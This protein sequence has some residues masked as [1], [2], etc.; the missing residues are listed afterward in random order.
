MRHHQILV[1]VAGLALGATTAVTHASAADKA[2][3]SCTE[4]TA[5]RTA[6]SIELT[7]LTAS[8]E[9]KNVELGEAASARKVAK[10]ESRRT[11]L[12]R[13]SEGLRRELTVLLDREHEHSDRVA[14]LDSLLA[15]KKCGK[16]GGK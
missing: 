8:V 9:Q 6:R 14:S 2:E 10:V 7:R 15:K 1:V 4:L 12:D 3:P 5:E 11:E 16:R 13:R